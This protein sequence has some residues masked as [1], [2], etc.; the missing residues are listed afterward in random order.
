MEVQAGL[1]LRNIVRIQHIRD[2]QVIHEEEGHNT[3]MTQGLNW[4]RGLIGDSGTDRA[5]YISCS[6]AGTIPNASGTDLTTPYTDY[7]LE[8]AAG[9][10]A[11]GADGVFTCAKTFTN[12]DASTHVVASVGLSWAATADTLFAAYVLAASVSLE[13]NDQVAVTWTVSLAES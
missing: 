4:L 8:K 1:T 13:Q 3:V 12:T 6:S 7:G 11:T 5:K 9:T 10:Y 2:G